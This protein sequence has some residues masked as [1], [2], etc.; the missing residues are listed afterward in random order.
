M[1]SKRMKSIR[2]D[3]VAA[4]WYKLF[5]IFCFVLTFELDGSACNV[6][7]L[8]EAFNLLKFIKV[9]GETFFLFIR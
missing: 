7:K 6:L 4:R 1:L 9:T 2:N 3:E 5:S 8:I